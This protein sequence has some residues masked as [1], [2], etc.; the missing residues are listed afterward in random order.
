MTCKVLKVNLVNVC[1]YF[2]SPSECITF[3]PR[4]QA[5][6]SISSVLTIN[7]PTSCPVAFK[8]NTAFVLIP[9]LKYH[10]IKKENEHRLLRAWITFV[11]VRTMTKG[12]LMVVEIKY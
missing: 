9:L 11:G 1:C 10:K 4:N 2:C 12:M 3:D 8:V 5:G 7:N 6:D